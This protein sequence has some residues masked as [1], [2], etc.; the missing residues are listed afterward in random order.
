MVCEG[1]SVGVP[2]EEVGIEKGFHLLSRWE[3]V[4]VGFHLECGL[5]LFSGSLTS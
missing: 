3:G 1:A 2:V 4:G 5:L